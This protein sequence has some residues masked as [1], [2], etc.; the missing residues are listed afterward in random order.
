[1]KIV[2]VVALIGALLATGTT[3]SF[4]EETLGQMMASG[5]MSEPAFTQFIQFTG[6]T[7]D[8]AK[9][10]TMSEVAKKHWGG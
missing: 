7:P 6:L 10:L 3:A 1:M 4:A 2:P 9:D 8:K 5:K